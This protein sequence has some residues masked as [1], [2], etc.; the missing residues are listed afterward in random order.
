MSDKTSNTSNEESLTYAQQLKLKHEEHMATYRARQQQKKEM[1]SAEPIKRSLTTEKTQSNADPTTEAMTH[2]ERVAQRRKEH[3]EAFRQHE[4]QR[5]LSENQKV[6][7][8][9]ELM[10]SQKLKKE[11]QRLE[12]ERKEQAQKQESERLKLMAITGLREIVAGKLPLDGGDIAMLFKNLNLKDFHEDHSDFFENH[13][14]E[15]L[16]WID[17][18]PNQNVWQFIELVNKKESDARI[19]RE[20]VA[21]ELRLLASISTHSSALHKKRRQLLW[22]SDYGVVKG[23]DKWLREIQ[24]FINDVVKP[25]AHGPLEYEHYAS[26]VSKLLDTHFPVSQPTAAIEDMT[27][28]DFELHCAKILQSAGWT[29]LHN[30]KTG[31]QGVDLIAEMNGLRV[32]LQCKRYAGSVGNTAVQ[33]VFAGHRYEACEV[34]AVV[35]N[36][37][38]TASAVQLAQTLNVLLIDISELGRLDSIVRTAISGN[39]R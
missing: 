9:Q 34:A 20:R 29:V 3:L 39:Q 23:L 14:P 35:S 37:K 12:L 7:R 22:V 27:G 6:E 32:A 17:E 2:M 11:K 15:L 25:P 21:F 26:E 10:Q 30:G 8:K 31:D 5:A 16:E 28:S 38:F 24:E 18:Q 36:A 33:E 13:L 1:L 4:H 19:E